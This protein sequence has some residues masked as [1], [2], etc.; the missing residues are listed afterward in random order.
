MQWKIFITAFHLTHCAKTIFRTEQ[1]AFSR[2]WLFYSFDLYIKVPPSSWW[3][4]RYD[5]AYIRYM[6]YASTWL[7]KY[8]IT[9]M[10]GRVRC[11]QF[12]VPT[13]A[14]NGLVNVLI[15]PTLTLVNYH[16]AC[17]ES[18]WI[19]MNYHIDKM[20]YNIDCRESLW[21]KVKVISGVIC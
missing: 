16:I 18:L 8:V 14:R 12:T 9:A 7:A 10:I 17:R 11:S 6:I 5:M 19:K 1:S 2:I 13:L 20:N 15:V 3:Y 21:M 4:G